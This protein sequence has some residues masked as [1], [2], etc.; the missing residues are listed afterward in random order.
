MMRE[1][2][3]G[4][5][6]GIAL[7]AST[8]EVF[9]NLKRQ[10]ARR[11]WKRAKSIISIGRMLNRRLSVMKGYDEVVQRVMRVLNLFLI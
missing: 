8:E 11:R 7:D 6:Q 2:Y 4:K 5:T 9:N 3:G 1:F 10:A